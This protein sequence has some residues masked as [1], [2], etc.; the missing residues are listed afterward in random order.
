MTQTAW[1]KTRAALRFGGNTVETAGKGAAAGAATN[2]DDP[3]SGAKL[4]PELRSAAAR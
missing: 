4:A 1:P 2:P 3:L